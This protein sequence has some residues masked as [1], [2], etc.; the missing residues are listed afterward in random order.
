MKEK[1]GKQFD[2]LWLPELSKYYQWDAE[3][4]EDDR[5]QIVGKKPTFV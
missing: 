3:R 2:I 4:T 5:R 1:I